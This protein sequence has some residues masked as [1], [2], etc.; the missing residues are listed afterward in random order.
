MKTEQDQGSAKF[1]KK[2]LDFKN[3]NSGLGWFGDSLSCLWPSRRF[4]YIVGL[5]VFACWRFTRRLCADRIFYWLL[6]LTVIFTWWNPASPVVPKPAR[7]TRGG[8]PVPQHAKLLRIHPGKQ[9]NKSS[10]WSSLEL[11]TPLTCRC[12]HDK[13]RD[14]NHFYFNSLF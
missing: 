3:P 9:G 14:W 5:R 6:T 13:E 7:F 8:H 11:H 10:V 2:L 4:R 12:S 1:Y